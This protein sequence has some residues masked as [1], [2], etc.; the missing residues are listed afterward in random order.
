MRYRLLDLSRRNPLLSTRFSANSASILRVVDELPEVLARKLCEGNKLTF[1]P[2]PSLGDSDP[3]EETAEFKDALSCARLEDFEYRS[4][5]AAIDQSAEENLNKVQLLER[6]L[7]DRVR[8]SIGLPPRQEKPDQTSLLQHAINCGISPN[9]ELPL[10]SEAHEDGRHHDNRIQTLLL[11]EQLERRSNTLSLRCRTIEQETGVN[12]LKT[13]FG[14]LEWQDQKMASS[15]YAPLILLPVHLEK[16]LTPT[17]S[18]FQLL[19]MESEAEGNIVLDMKFRTAFD[20][21]LPK[22]EDFRRQASPP[23]ST[24]EIETIED[25]IAKIGTINHK[26]LKKCKVHRQ[27]AIGLFPSAQMIM[28]EDLDPET[29]NLD[30]KAIEEL[31]S[32]APS[33]ESLT[34]APDY[35]VDGPNIENKI[36]GLAL[37]ADSSQ[38]SA[39]V[40]AMDGKNLAVEGPPGTGKSQTITNVIANAIAAGKK[41]LFVAEKLAALEVVY[42]KLKRLGLDVH[43]LPLHSTK[44]SREQVISS[45]RE[46]L[47]HREVSSSAIRDLEMKKQAYDAARERLA[48]YITVMQQPYGSGDNVSTV[49]GKGIEKWEVLRDLPFPLRQQTAMSLETVEKCY[50][51]MESIIE[52]AREF[53]KSWRLALVTDSAWQGVRNIGADIIVRETMQYLL[54]EASK[55]LRKEAEKQTAVETLGL[56]M[57]PG[58]LDEIEDLAAKF[59]AL[60]SPP[61]RQLLSQAIR[62]NAV[63]AILSFL[64]NCIK[65]Q[66]E[67][68]DLAKTVTQTDD[69]SVVDNVRQIHA[70][71]SANNHLFIRPDEWRSQ[72][73]VFE[74]ECNEIR[75]SCIAVEMFMQKHP[76]LAGVPVNALSEAAA[77]LRVTDIE[78]YLSCT[79]A[80]SELAA[81]GKA[82]S[83]CAAGRQ[84]V[85]EQKRLERSVIVSEIPYE[86]VHLEFCAEVLATTGFFGKFFSKFKTA[87]AVYHHIANTNVF[88]QFQ[89]ASDMRALAKWMRI[90]EQFNNDKAGIALFNTHFKGIDSDFDLLE[91]TVAYSR[92]VI[93]MFANENTGNLLP[94]MLSGGRRFIDAILEIPENLPGQT[95][96]QLQEK[97]LQDEKKLSQTT[98]FV[99]KAT[100]LLTVLTAPDDTIVSLLPTIAERL[101]KHQTS[102]E[103]LNN[104][105][106]AAACLQTL[107]KGAATRVDS[108]HVEIEALRLLQQFRGRQDLILPLIA[109]G[110]WQKAVESISEYREAR[111]ESAR[112]MQALETQYGIPFAKRIAGMSPVEAAAYLDTAAKDEDGFRIHVDHAYKR[113]LVAEDELVWAID[114]FEAE[115]LAPADFSKILH[116]VIV[117]A[118]VNAIDKKYGPIVSGDKYNGEKLA[119]LRGEIAK[120]DQDITKLNKLLIDKRTYASCIHIP[121]KLGK[122]VSQHSEGAL[123]AHEVGKKGCSFP[124][125]NLL[126]VLEKLCG[127]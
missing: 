2:L 120:L 93:S 40:D 84:L 34:F 75:K 126:G 30:G 95:L 45:I 99:L 121:G 98:D 101:E 17:G 55:A 88:A 72:L 119:K 97:L 74:L 56:P 61:D 20:T 4:A 109:T 50:S 65:F 41:V 91:K 26:S 22:Y 31:F 107:Y 10:P 117:R 38:F 114:I 19:A 24:K 76:E 48:E 89:A 42:S 100:P 9:Y 110:G 66:R 59:Q 96:A 25:Y 21:A 8:A 78:A 28:F 108:M 67:Q 103:R 68:L 16:I 33:G 5:L 111:S 125:V 47:E 52:H 73:R 35:N 15:S 62:H 80:L 37:E 64:L 116:A 112:H 3:L 106:T 127:S 60:P 57:E 12:S 90:T 27:V 122:L 14:F 29:L 86:P 79:P 104:D 1:V 115:R 63:D 13:A 46:R 87:K 54:N 92:K 124:P 81:I 85:V 70:L 118:A 39:I 36:T 69:S 18:E 71:C 102:A 11:Q 6:E 94:L 83:I 44:S 23:D 82:E 53:E 58:S 77:L 113:C 7:K 32:G 49:I 43:T 105:A 123:I 51:Q